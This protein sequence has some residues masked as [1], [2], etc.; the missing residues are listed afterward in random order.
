MYRVTAQI[1]YSTEPSLAIHKT[2]YESE[3]RYLGEG[4]LV[5]LLGVSSLP[6]GVKVLNDVLKII[7]RNL[8]TNPVC[9][10]SLR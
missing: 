2:N 10:M 8:N 4:A 9:L 3:D 6:C 5:E 1:F 7:R